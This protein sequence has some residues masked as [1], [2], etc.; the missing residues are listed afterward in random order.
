MSDIAVEV[1]LEPEILIECSAAVGI[2]SNVGTGEKK[3]GVDSGYYRQ[4]SITD[5]YLFICVLEGEA[6]TAIWKKTIL[7]QTL[8]LNKKGN[9]TYRI[10][11]LIVSEAL[12]LHR[13]KRHSNYH[14]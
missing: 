1:T 13:Q 12:Y 8:Y 3:T 4:I 9:K 10:G 2:L 14:Y 11:Q 6:G 5:D 7:F